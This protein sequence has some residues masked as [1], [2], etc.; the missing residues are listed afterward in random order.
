MFALGRSWRGCL[1]RHEG[2]VDSSNLALSKERA[3]SVRLAL[4]KLDASLSSRLTSQ[5]LGETKPQADNNTLEGRAR[6]RRVELVLQ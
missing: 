1:I 5:G 4:I 2:C 3:E 6:N